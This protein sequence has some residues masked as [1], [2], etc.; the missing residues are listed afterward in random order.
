MVLCLI[1]CRGWLW[2]LD[3]Q[4][5]DVL[6]FIAKKENLTLPPELAGRIAHHSNR[7]LRRSILCLE[8]CKAQQY[9]SFLPC[10]SWIFCSSS[11]CLRFY[12]LCGLLSSVLPYCW[13]SECVQIHPAS[14]SFCAVLPLIVAGQNV[15]PP[16]SLCLLYFFL[17]RYPFTG[18]QVVQT[19][20]WEQFIVEVA[21]DIVNE[22]SPKR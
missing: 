16:R 9:V 6:L 17:C 11:L 19:T 14:P 21:N 1:K 12:L 5:V 20:D 18:N 15:A 22:Q 13:N 8:A 10:L 2:V 4:I 3:C 7:N